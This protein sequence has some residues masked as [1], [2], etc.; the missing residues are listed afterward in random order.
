M[1]VGIEGCVLVSDWTVT[2]SV[3]VVDAPT[4]A[5]RDALDWAIQHSNFFVYWSVSLVVAD[6]GQTFL[7]KVGVLAFQQAHSLKVRTLFGRLR[8]ISCAD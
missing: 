4:V 2:V 8:P 1:G 5:I 6:P 7:K 3:A